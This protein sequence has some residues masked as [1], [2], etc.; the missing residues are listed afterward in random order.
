[1]SD[2]AL[3][4]ALRWHEDGK[5][6]SPDAPSVQHTQAL[7]DE[8]GRLRAVL[9]T[10]ELVDF[11]RAVV[12]EAAHQRERWGEAHDARKAPEDWFW[13]L[14]YLA[15]KALHAARDG[16][17]QKALH[18]MISSAALLNNWHRCTISPV[19]HEA[20]GVEDVNG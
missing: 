6:G 12:L 19:Q 4:A 2:D 9:N 11:G 18:H 13:A 5:R 10:P 20:I 3:Q 1:M 8:I 16:E 17:L 14:G 15:G 7:V